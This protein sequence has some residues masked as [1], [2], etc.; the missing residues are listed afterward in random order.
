MIT[1]ST[2]QPTLQPAVSTPRLPPELMDQIVDALSDDVHSLRTCALSSRQL[3]HRSRYQLFRAIHF[4]F[5]IIWLFDRCKIFLEKCCNVAPLVRSLTLSGRPLR[6]IGPSCTRIPP[7]LQLPMAFR[8]MKNL[9][10]LHLVMVELVGVN[11]IWPEVEELEMKDCSVTNL[12][13]FLGGFHKLKKLMLRDVKI[14]TKTSSSSEVSL[15][16]EELAIIHGR[17]FPDMNTIMCLLPLLPMPPRIRRLTYPLYILKENIPQYDVIPYMHLDE[18][19]LVASSEPRIP[20]PDIQN[21]TRLRLLVYPPWRWDPAD[22]C[23]EC[24]RLTDWLV[25][26]LHKAQGG[27]LKEL[28]FEYYLFGTSGSPDKWAELDRILSKME[29]SKVDLVF[30]VPPEELQTEEGE[31]SEWP[32]WKEELMIKNAVYFEQVKRGRW[33]RVSRGY[34]S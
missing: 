22:A 7:E 19:F 4:P 30:N 24:D 28:E 18:L 27:C 2:S 11:I 34:R 13:T 8:M 29:L 12:G 31:K 26:L 10:S 3:V 5:I 17:K 32:F 25:H 14:A 21:I 6:Y 15:D 23:K 33:L 16:L 20:V 1:M 9:T